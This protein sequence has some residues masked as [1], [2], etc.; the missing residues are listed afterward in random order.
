MQTAK[1]KKKKFKQ[2]TSRDFN[3]TASSGDTRSRSSIVKLPR[4]LNFLTSP[5]LHVLVIITFTPV[6]FDKQADYHHVFVLRS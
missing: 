4:L 3:C 6:A 2:Y 5:L 1:M